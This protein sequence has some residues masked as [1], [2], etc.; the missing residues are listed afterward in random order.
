MIQNNM[1]GIGL[2]MFGLVVFFVTA[3]PPIT[4]TKPLA[5]VRYIS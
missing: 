1:I 4:A 5:T 3:A 2:V